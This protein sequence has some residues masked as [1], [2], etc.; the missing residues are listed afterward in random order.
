M[1][2]CL[3]FDLTHSNHYQSDIFYFFT[4]GFIVNVNSL[5]YMCSAAN[6]ISSWNISMTYLISSLYQRHS[7]FTLHELFS[8]IAQTFGFAEFGFAKFKPHLC[9][10]NKTI[11]HGKHIKH[12]QREFVISYN[13][14]DS[15]SKIIDW[16][17]T[18][19]NAAK[20]TDFPGDFPKRQI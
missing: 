5:R 12:R 17:P 18:G 1:K 14:G 3:T 16:L 8:I 19:P 9:W 2:I 7:E 13:F 10:F 4:A 15:P 6:R 11:S 20:R